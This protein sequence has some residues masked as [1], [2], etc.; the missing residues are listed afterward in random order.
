MPVEFDGDVLGI[1]VETAAGLIE[2]VTKYRIDGDTLIL[3]RL[4][5]H[6]PGAGKIGTARLFRLAQELGRTF[7]VR[8]IVIYGAGRTTGAAPGH[9]PRPITIKVNDDA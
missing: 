6:G 1:S 4:H 5:I 9:L 3:D 7:G 8:R 2:V